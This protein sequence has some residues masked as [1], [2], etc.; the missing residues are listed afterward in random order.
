MP[1][2]FDFISYDLLELSILVGIVIANAFLVLGGYLLNKDDSN[3]SYVQY[4]LTI[5]F[6]LFVYSILDIFLPDVTYYS[7]AGSDPWQDVRYGFTYDFIR[8]QGFE[9]ALLVTLGMSFVLIALTNRQII[10][11]NFLLLAGCCLILASFLSLANWGFYYFLR[12]LWPQD[13]L[14]YYDFFI[15]L[16]LFNLFLSI[17][18]FGF[19]SLFSYRFNQ[20]FLLLFG[21]LTIILLFLGVWDFITV[22]GVLS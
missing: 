20:K 12:W 16:Q 4:L 1:L 2:R 21:I 14:V 5:G 8:F 9:L 3:L 7:A 10:V 17:V 18:A 6:G 22:F 13:F 15:P 11:D 19:F